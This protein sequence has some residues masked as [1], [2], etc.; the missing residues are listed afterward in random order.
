MEL[1]PLAYGVISA[2]TLAVMT[3]FASLIIDLRKAMKPQ[4]LGSSTIYWVLRVIAG[5][6][7][8][9]FGATTLFLKL[10][11][12]L[13]M[14]P[15]PSSLPGIALMLGGVGYPA[16]A[17]TLIGTLIAGLVSQQLAGTSAFGAVLLVG[18][19]LPFILAQHRRRSKPSKARSLGEK[20]GFLSVIAMAAF[21]FTTTL[22]VAPTGLAGLGEFS[23]S[24]LLIPPLA[25][26]LFKCLGFVT[27]LIACPN[28]SSRRIDIYLGHSTVNIV[29]LG[30]ILSSG[31]RLAESPLVAL[32]LT[33]SVFMFIC[34]DEK[35]L[36]FVFEREFNARAKKEIRS[37]IG[38]LVP[39]LLSEIA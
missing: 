23:S 28:D 30:T 36:Q 35:L 27:S 11:A 10:F 6:A 37:E 8:F 34:V 4:A 15:P 7:L 2:G 17:V 26:L 22:K 14:T 18:C 20:W 24:A 16:F 19:A 33:L 1:S 32:S 38:G 25:L 12:I 9:H 13:L 21:A 31:S 5:A 29:L 39:D 3:F